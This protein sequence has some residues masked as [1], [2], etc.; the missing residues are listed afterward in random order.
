MISG[1]FELSQMFCVYNSIIKCEVL[2]EAGPKTAE[3]QVGVSNYRKFMGKFDP[4]HSKKDVLRPKY[5][6]LN[7]NI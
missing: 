5:S 1:K 2:L 7:Q 4:F 3:M 6:V